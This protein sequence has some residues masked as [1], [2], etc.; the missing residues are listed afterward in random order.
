MKTIF[1]LLLFPLLY[2]LQIPILKNFYSGLKFG[3]WK[4]FNTILILSTLLFPTYL[5]SADACAP[6]DETSIMS[7]T[8]T[9]DTYTVSIAKNDS[10]SYYIQASTAGTLTITTNNTNNKI[11]LNGSES[12]CPAATVSG[13]T[14]LTYSDTTAFDINVV[15][16]ASNAET[17]TLTIVFTPDTSNTDPTFT[18]TPITTAT[19]SI[20]Y[21]YTVATD[22][23]DGDTVTVA[24]TTIPA[25]LSFDGTTL[26]GIPTAS[27]VGPHSVILTANDGNGGTATQSFTIT[28]AASG[29]NTP[30]TFTSTP[31]TT[32]LEGIEYYYT[33]TTEDVNNDTVIVTATTLPS[34]LAFDGYNLIGEPNA[35]DVGDHNVTLTAD[36]GTDTTDQNFTITVEA[37][38]PDLSISKVD[39]AAGGPVDVST[40]FYYTITVNNKGS[41]TATGVSVTDT[42]PPGLDINLT[43]SNASSSDWNCTRSVDVITCSLLAEDGNLSITTNRTITLHATA[44]FTAG[45]ITNTASVTL[46]E[47]DY[48]SSNNV[49]TETTKIVSTGYQ[50]IDEA[51]EL[52]YRD[53]TNLTDPTDCIKVGNFY[54]GEGC[55]ATILIKSDENLN[56][57]LSDVNVTVMIAVSNNKDLDG[58]SCTSTA[59]NCSG[60]VPFAPDFSPSYLEAYIVPDVGSMASDSNFTIGHSDTHNKKPLYQIAVYAT[61][62]YDGVY[63]YGRVYNCDGVSEGGITAIAYADTIDT[64]ID[65]GNA[66]AYN[67]SSDTS[68]N[69]LKYIQTMVASDT[70]SITAVHLDATTKEA[71]PYIEPAGYNGSLP[72]YVV[73]QLVATDSSGRCLAPPETIYAADGT[74]PLRI[75][76]TTG[77]YSGSSVMTV[78]DVVRKDARLQLIIVDPRLLSTDG[79]DCLATSSTSGNLEGIGQC[80]N[81]EGQYIAGFSVD[82]WDRCGLNNGAPC[83]SKN[84]G[85]SG[86]SDP[87][88]PGYNPI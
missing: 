57:N 17:H 3:H 61:Y 7:L 8:N 78:S 24:G 18:S 21:S 77:N 16:F 72:F 6:S 51:N 80:A 29:I 1:N 52:C 12:I 27:D 55:D 64:Y 34:W 65:V 10:I 73:P 44:P 74:T 69:G 88:Y 46:N 41:A 33:V 13:S 82:A 81:S 63:H 36:D 39:S 84:G 40:G 56:T 45:T 75:P 67:A 9:S 5:F 37:V 38:A 49:A 26:S 19:E 35:T 48:D 30:P 50:E 59:G 70:R 28:V 79:Q 68:N 15:V 11:H 20:N 43:T 22:D 31:I 71:I 83:L 58:G 85:Y 66:A 62:N 42:L 53:T 86:G 54:Y 87:T 60:P 2:L 14:S 47:S 25:W 23:T 76:V 4:K 32:A